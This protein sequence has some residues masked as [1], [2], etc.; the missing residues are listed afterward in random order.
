VASLW[1]F[2]QEASRAKKT[3]TVEPPERHIISL[4]MPYSS[5]M[6]NVERVTQEDTVL[7]L[8]SQ[9][10]SYMEM[11]DNRRGDMLRRQMILLTTSTRHSTITDPPLT[12]LFSPPSCTTAGSTGPVLAQINRLHPAEPHPSMPA[13]PRNTGLFLPATP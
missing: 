12:S 9:Y 13:A 5:V 2:A 1:S 6:W 11:W 3:V 7:M 8:I 10:G 4:A